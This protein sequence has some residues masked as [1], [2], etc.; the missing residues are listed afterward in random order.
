MIDLLKEPNGQFQFDQMRTIGQNFGY[1]HYLYVPLTFNSHGQKS[2]QLP[3]SGYDI[4]WGL[5]CK[6]K[7]FECRQIKIHLAKVGFQILYYLK[8]TWSTVW[9]M[10]HTVCEIK[11]THKL[12][13]ISVKSLF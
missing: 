11:S 7:V 10:Q 1:L 2:L 12:M 9:C 8:Y 3:W 4:D 6:M 13:H 5:I